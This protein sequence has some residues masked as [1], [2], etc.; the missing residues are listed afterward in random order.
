MGHLILFKKKN[1]KLQKR[2]RG[3][4]GKGKASECNIRAKLGIYTKVSVK[5]IKIKFLM[6]SDVSCCTF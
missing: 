6:A 1:Q 4:D 2:E 5:N 3:C